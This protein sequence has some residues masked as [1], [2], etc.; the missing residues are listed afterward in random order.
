MNKQC[1]EVEMEHRAWSECPLWYCVKTTLHNNGKIESE[2]YANEKTG[3]PVV[4]QSDDKPQ[5][6]VF[7]SATKT[8]YFTY[9]KGY[10]AAANVVE[11]TKKMSA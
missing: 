6:G 1:I 8:T 4:I 5:D 11:S 7:E 2:I 3:I 10:K 9:C